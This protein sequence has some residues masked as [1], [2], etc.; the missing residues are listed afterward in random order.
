MSRHPNKEIEAALKYAEGR[1]WRIVQ[2]K[3]GHVWERIYCPHGQRGGCA[4]SVYSTPRNP[5]KHARELRQFVERC[6]HTTD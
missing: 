4:R 6:P 5:D 3:H 1:G 2:S